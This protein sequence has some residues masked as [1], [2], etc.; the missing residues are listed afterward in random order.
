M[1]SKHNSITLQQK[2]TRKEVATKDKYVGSKN[3]L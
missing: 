2:V 3:N 1:N